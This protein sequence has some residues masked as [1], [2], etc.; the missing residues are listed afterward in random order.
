MRQHSRISFRPDSRIKVTDRLQGTPLGDT[1]D[2]SL[3][4]LRLIAGAALEVGRR[5][6]MVLHVPQHNG[7]VREIEVTMV[8]QWAKRSLRRGLFEMGFSLEQPAPAFT[9]LV[10]A[11]LPRRAR[12]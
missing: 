11:Q 2:I 8:C 10:A 7:R 9:E 5:Y 4:G 3:G 12:G 6:E 1:G